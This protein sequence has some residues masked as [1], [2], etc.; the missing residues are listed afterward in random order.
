MLKGNKK[1]L[2]T[3]CS[4]S[5]KNMHFVSLITP[6]SFTH[7]DPKIK[8]GLRFSWTMNKSHMSQRTGHRD[9]ASL[10]KTWKW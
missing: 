5:K 6:L 7:K 2:K 8:T 3:I 4:T 9:T 1:I 10:S